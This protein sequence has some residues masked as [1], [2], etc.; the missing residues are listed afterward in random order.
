MMRKILK[1]RE[2]KTKLFVEGCRG[3]PNEREVTAGMAEFF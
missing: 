3:R 1:V 2:R